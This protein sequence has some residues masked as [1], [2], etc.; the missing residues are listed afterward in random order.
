M[1]EKIVEK[2]E[3]IT[4]QDIFLEKENELIVVKNPE[5]KDTNIYDIYDAVSTKKIKSIP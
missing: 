4:K 5:N 3:Y 1:K 2:Y